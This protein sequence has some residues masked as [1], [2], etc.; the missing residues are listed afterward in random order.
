MKRLI[1]AAA[2]AAAGVTASAAEAAAL[3]VTMWNETVGCFMCKTAP[4]AV[5]VY[6]WDKID[7]GRHTARMMLMGAAG[8]SKSLIL[9]V[10]DIDGSLSD[11]CQ[12]IDTYCRENGALDLR[13]PI[14]LN[15]RGGSVLAGYCDCWVDLTPGDSLS[16][17]VANVFIHVEFSNLHGRRE[18]VNPME[19][20]DGFI[21]TVLTAGDIKTVDVAEGL[22][23]LNMAQ[24][25]TGGV[26]K[27]LAASINA[28]VNDMRCY[29]DFSSRP[30]PLDDGSPA[31]DEL[32]REY[33]GLADKARIDRQDFGKAREW[34]R[35]A[36]E[37]GSVE[38][39]RAFGESLTCGNVPYDESEEGELWLMKA[40]AKGDTSSIRTL[41]MHYK[42]KAMEM[43]FTKP[44][45]DTSIDYAKAAY[46]L[47][48]YADLDKRDGW[49]CYALSCLFHDG[50]GVSPD[51][52]TAF[53]YAVKAV[54]LDDDKT[55]LTNLAAYYL[56][57]WG[58]ER[59]TEMVREMCEM[60]LSSDSVS[61]NLKDEARELLDSLG[62]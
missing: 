35:K 9:C 2:V 14:T 44:G 25:H 21:T 17:E 27:R 22:L 33:L 20:H 41:G 16:R 62:D 15:M 49:T 36:A 26:I 13:F 5:N 6:E 50:L 29:S 31:V 18:P 4:E 48:R 53:S 45:Y 30:A 38:A 61:R 52:G 37:T 7:D 58:V 8:Q 42:I 59:N 32:A 3:S 40:I 56:N 54:E 46:W 24:M 39:M 47:H 60:V 43:G 51:D 11:V 34:G 12:A 28:C 55:F 57:G 19:A 10:A 23:V 1:I